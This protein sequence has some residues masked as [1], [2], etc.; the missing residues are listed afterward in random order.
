M[1]YE[2]KDYITRM[3]KQ[4]GEVLGG[5]L[6]KKDAEEILS[7]GEEQRASDTLED[8]FTLRKTT[9]ADIPEILMIFEGATNYLKEQGSPQWQDGHGPDESS[10][11]RDMA[12]DFSYVLVQ[13][14]ETIIGTAALVGGIDPVYEAI[15]GTWQGD[16]KYVSIHR[17]AVSQKTRSKG[18]GNLL[19]VKAIEKAKELG[20]YD[21][22]IDTYP[23][24][25][26]M[27]R[28]IDKLGFTYCGMVHFPF[29]HGERKAF[30]LLD[31]K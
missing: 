13:K 5:L 19:L 16:Q 15:D 10:I 2:D 20:Y 18:L 11:L 12:A 31:I 23:G 8:A 28:L 22:R 1:G 4:A 29:E 6:G 3:A 7:F 9:K 27:L 30:Q 24:N 26:P 14:N 25:K 17:V 21:I